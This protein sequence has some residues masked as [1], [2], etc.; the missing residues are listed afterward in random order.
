[1][2]LKAELENFR[3]IN[4]EEIVPEVDKITANVR[5]SILLYNKAIESLRSGSEDIAV[6]GLKKATSMNPGFNEAFNLLGICYSYMGER[7]KAA[8][9]FNRVIKAESNSVLAMNIMQRLGMG[10]ISQTAQPAQKPKQV[11]KSL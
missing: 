10:D 5:N 7:E 3:P 6:I 8:E 2:D 9:A 4:L 1:M 11:K